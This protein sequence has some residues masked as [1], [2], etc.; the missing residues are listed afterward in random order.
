MWEPYA[1]YYRTALLVKKIE[2][3]K[4]WIERVDRNAITKPKKITFKFG[5]PESYEKENITTTTPD[6]AVSEKTDVLSVIDDMLETAAEPVIDPTMMFD[7]EIF[8]NENIVPTISERPIDSRRR[9]IAEPN[10]SQMEV[11]EYQEERPSPT[12]LADVAPNYDI[13]SEPTPV[14]DVE[15]TLTRAKETSEPIE[16]FEHIDIKFDVGNVDRYEEATRILGDV[17]S[18]LWFTVN[19]DNVSDNNA[20]QK[21]EAFNRCVEN[22][23]MNVKID[24]D[25]DSLSKSTKLKLATIAIEATDRN[26]R[27][28]PISDDVP[29]PTFEITITDKN[30]FGEFGASGGI[31]YRTF[32]ESLMSLRVHTDVYESIKNNHYLNLKLNESY[33]GASINASKTLWGFWFNYNIYFKRINDVNH[34]NMRSLLLAEISK[35]RQDLFAHN[36]TS[37]IN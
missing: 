13:P 35:C 10:E 21:Y 33:H 15:S 20:R 27:V 29:K 3:L 7:D 6:S 16:R 8:Q 25:V 11:E 18:T 36:M 37:E 22:V 9:Q 31:Y 12:I 26:S 32:D 14:L 28:A 5:E 2:P 1:T 4:L 30:D 17:L 19:L 34:E 23:K 24:V